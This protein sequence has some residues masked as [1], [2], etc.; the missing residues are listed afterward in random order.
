MIVLLFGGSSTGKTSLATRTRER[1]DVPFLH[2]QMDMLMGMVPRWTIEHERQ[3]GA[4]EHGG[5]WWS[6]RAGSNARLPRFGP[7]ATSV[8]HGCH[9]AVRA[10]ADSGLS[11]L[12]DDVLYDRAWLD[13]YLRVLDGHTVVLVGVRCEP[14]E[15]LS[16]ARR[17]PDR[18]IGLIEGDRQCLYT[19]DVVDLEIETSRTSVDAC[20]DLLI[21][22]LR[23]PHRF[24]AW[25]RLL[26]DMPPAAGAQGRDRGCR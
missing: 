2:V 4:P 16:R 17:R 11:L 8:I 6:Q 9:Q 1:L 5:F 25:A 20:A 24:S 3:G 12:V 14:D 26:D 22:L 10:L 18:H 13:D 7:F 19:P 15:L 21:D 23:Q